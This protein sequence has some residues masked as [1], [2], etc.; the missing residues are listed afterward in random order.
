MD[1][2]RDWSP[3]PFDCKGL[4]LPDRQD[5]VVV[6][7][8]RTRDTA[9]LADSNFEFA[10]KEFE[11]LD[12]AG[13]DH[14]NHCFTHWASGWF[15]ILLVRPATPCH[16]A[17]AEIASALTNYTVLDEADL[18]QREDALANEVWLGLSFRERIDLCNRYDV[19]FLRARHDCYPRDDQ[20]AI[21]SY[22]ISP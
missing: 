18:S 9:I 1:R 4:D 22:L 7:V 17:A 14:E 15:E 13:V 5:W 16:Q 12:P 19:C 11:K 6:P 10:T 21:L 8:I 20:G 3:T 2:Y